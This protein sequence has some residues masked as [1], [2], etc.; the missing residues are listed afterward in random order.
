MI[1]SAIFLSIITILPIIII[2]TSNI[3]NEYTFFY[4]KK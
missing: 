1:L 3:N 4:N 2:F